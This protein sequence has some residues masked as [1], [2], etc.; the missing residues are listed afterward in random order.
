MKRCESSK[1]LIQ[2]IGAILNSACPHIHR[3]E[4]GLTI[5]LDF[6]RS[7]HSGAATQPQNCESKHKLPSSKMRDKI[8]QRV[9]LTRYTRGVRIVFP[10]QKYDPVTVLE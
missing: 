5:V 1:F 6:S 8:E 4:R 9:M 3:V 7:V 10:E 2:A